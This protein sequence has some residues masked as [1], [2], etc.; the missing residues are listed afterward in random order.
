LP[1]R[2]IQRP[3]ATSRESAATEQ[4]QQNR[5]EPRRL[6]LSSMQHGYVVIVLRLIVMPVMLVMAVGISTSAT[7]AA[8]SPIAL[9][10]APA[11][12]L[13]V[14]AAALPRCAVVRWLCPASG[15][16]GVLAAVRRPVTWRPDIARCGHGGRG[17][18]PNGRRRCAD[19]DGDLPEG[20]CRESGDGKN[21]AE[22]PLSLHRLPCCC[23]RSLAQTLL[24]TGTLRPAPWKKTPGK[25]VRNFPFHMSRG[26]LRACKSFNKQLIFQI[27]AKALSSNE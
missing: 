19:V 8:R 3:A 23:A 2:W 11:A 4:R 26:R 9:T 12:R 24:P 7:P 21:A 6:R 10:I 13:V 20:G 5:G 14:P 25:F 22:Q 17:L 15:S 18:I 16:P 1:D 27:H